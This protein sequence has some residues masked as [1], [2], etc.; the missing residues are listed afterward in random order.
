M[1]ELY[2][3]VYEFR[4]FAEEVTALRLGALRRSTGLYVCMS[5]QK[6][7]TL[8]P[9]EG[10]GLY[11]V[12]RIPAPLHYAGFNVHKEGVLQVTSVLKCYK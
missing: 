3:R 1:E 7:R 10:D 12:P 5:L 8:V 4:P 2:T 11:R 6:M 9:E